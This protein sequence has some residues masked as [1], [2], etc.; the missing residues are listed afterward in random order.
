MGAEID[1]PCRPLRAG[2][3]TD[4]FAQSPVRERGMVAAAMTE[5]LRRLAIVGVPNTYGEDSSAK[6]R[7]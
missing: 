3:A 4:G 6:R 7:R 1:R 5:A 2:C